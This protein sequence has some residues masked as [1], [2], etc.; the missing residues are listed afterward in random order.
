[1]TAATVKVTVVW[2]TPHIQDTVALT[3]P[4]GATVATAIARSGLLVAYGINA[5]AIRAGLHGRVVRDDTPLRDG[6]RVE[7][8]RPLVV[9]PKEARRLR[10]K[11]SHA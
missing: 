3:L 4:A 8:C 2:A 5:V 1:V 9:D 6:D 7:I 11:G 10:A